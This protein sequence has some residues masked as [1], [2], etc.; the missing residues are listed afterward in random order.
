[1]K[2]QAAA[3]I[4]NGY[5]YTFS[6]EHMSYGKKASE[7]YDIIV[8]A[9][10]FPYKSIVSSL[11][12]IL[13]NRRNVLEIGV[14]TG[15]VAIPLAKRSYTVSGVDVSTHMVRIT[16]RKARKG[17]IKIKLYVQD[18]SKLKLGRTFDVV[19]SQGGPF[20]YVGKDV[21]SYITNEA[22]IKIAMSRIFQH[23]N[24]GGLFLVSL[25]HARKPEIKVRIK[26]GLE[27]IQTSKSHGRKIVIT[28]V[29]KRKGK[30]VLRQVRH[31]SLINRSAF[32]KAMKNTG[33]KL[34]GADSAKKF[35]IYQKL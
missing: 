18:I 11:V 2:S 20:A 21:E 31:K 10:L 28:D 32:N 8:S 16:R 12:K 4:I 17:S 13:G 23:L 6:M 5:N 25:Q 34:K 14:G 19:Y 22:S 30:Q 7:F 35:F 1:M 29:V 15:N 33:F 9:G 24:T 3:V 26:S 27:Y